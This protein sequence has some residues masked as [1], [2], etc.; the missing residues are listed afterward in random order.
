MGTYRLSQ[1]LGLGATLLVEGDHV[2][3]EV[4]HGGPKG[5]GVDLGG[6][7]TSDQRPLALP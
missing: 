3:V 5:R 6:P 7:S 1:W 4:R 2:A